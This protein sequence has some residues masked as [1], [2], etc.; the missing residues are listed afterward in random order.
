MTANNK[1]ASTSTNGAISNGHA[2]APQS[3]SPP[4]T[5]SRNDLR[6]DKPNGHDPAKAPNG[7]PIAICGMALRLPGGLSTPKELWN[8]LLAKG[9]A[10]TRVPESRYRASSF[11]SDRAKPTTIATQ[12]GY[13][14]DE[15]VDIGALDASFFSMS[16]TEVE[17]A[18]P[19]Q[20]LMLEI[21]REAFEDAGVT[22]WRGKSIGCYVGSFGEDWL[23]L[24]A[25][26]TQPW[27]MFRVTGQG[28]FM[29]SNR[30]SYEMDLQGPSVTVR[31]ACS[32]SLT[33][34]SEA[35]MAIS[36]GAC[37][38]A[39][40]GGVNLMLS[41]TM[42]TAMTEQGVLSKDGSC[43]TFSVDADGYAR[44]E[45]ATAIFIKP[46]AD[47]LRDGNPVRAV[48]R[49]ACHNSDGRTQGVSVPSSEAQEALIR[50]TYKLAGL[51][52]FR[53]TAMVECHGTGTATG[54]PIEAAAVARVFGDPKKT[55]YIGSV[56]PN[57]GHAE[58]AS[59]LV[60]IIKS[61]LALENRIIPPNI[62]FRAPNPNIPFDSAGMVVP[63][64]ATPWPQS[65]LER[66]SV[67]SF[68]IGGANAHAVLD[69]AQ[70]FLSHAPASTRQPARPTSRP[71]LM[72][73]SGN[74]SKSA[75]AAAA[76]YRSW[77]E[78]NPE[79]TADLAYTL[80]RHRVH[81]PW[82][83]FAT[84]QN[85]VLGMASPPTNST[86]KH[87]IVMVFTGQGAQWPGMGKE[88][89]ASQPSFKASI[90]Y[91]DEQLREVQQH[92]PAHGANEDGAT[93][94]Y[95]IEEELLKPGKKSRVGTAR[96]SQPL[97][98][99]I[100][101]ALVDTLRSFGVIPLAV[102]GHSSGEIAAAYAAGALTAREAIIAAHH[103]G[104]VA[105]L[106]KKKGAMAAIGMS[107][108]ETSKF[109]VHEPQVTI[110]C[111][112]SPESVTIS[113]DADAV[114][115]VVAD[116]QNAKPAVLTRLL[117]VDKAYHSYH[118]AEIGDQYSALIGSSVCGKASQ[119]NV[120]FFSSVTGN[121][122][123]A[124]CGRRL[125][126]VY[127]RENLQSPVRFRQ[128]IVSIVNH[129]IIGKEDA[130]FLEIGP[131]GALAGP[132][133]QILT[134][135][136]VS[137]PYISTLTR[138][139]NSMESIISAMG[140]LHCLHEPIDLEA[141][142]P[143]GKCLSNLPTYPWNH[144]TSYWAE[145]R[146]SRDWRLRQYPHHDLLGSKAAESTEIEPIWRNLLH[147]DNI[148][149]IRD[150]KVGD[151]IVFPFAGYIALA[152][153]AVKR[154]SGESH[155]GFKIRNIIVSVA[156]V[157]SED[158]PTEI[159][160]AFR[161]RRLT[162]T[163]SSHWWEFTVASHNGHTWNRHCTGEVMALG[164]SL[165]GKATKP[166]LTSLPRRIEPAAWYGT[167]C[168]GGLDLGPGFQRI[169]E[170]TTST[171]A[172]RKAAGSIVHGGILDEGSYHIHPTVIDGTLQLM[173]VAAVN[174]YARKVK[175]WLPT[176]I[177]EISVFRCYQD[178][179]SL[180]CAS[181]TSNLS[182]LGQGR[183]V[184]DDGSLVLEATGIRMTL[185]DG[186]Q[187]PEGSTNP[188]AAARLT[189][190]PNIEFINVRELFQPKRDRVAQTGI[191]YELADL[192]LLAWQS[193][194]NTERLANSDHIEKYAQWMSS[195][196]RRHG[197]R[198]EDENSTIT[199]AKVADLAGHLRDTPLAPAA[200]A[201]QHI[202]ENMPQIWNLG[203]QDN[204]LPSE[205]L[206]NLHRFLDESVD[207]SRF[208]RLLGHWKPNLRILEL[209]TA[210]QQ[211]S[212]NAFLGHLTLPE[213]AVLCS[214]YTYTSTGFISAKDQQQTGFAN[215]EYATLDISK[216]PLEQGFEEGQYDLIVATNHISATPCL[217]ES[218]ANVRRLLSP[219]GRLLLRELCPTSKWINMIYGLKQ[220]WWCGADDNR[221]EEPYISP[222][223]W[224]S[225]LSAAGF[226]PEGRYVLDAPQP[227]QLTATIV[228]RHGRWAPSEASP[229][230][231]TMLC[232]NQ[233]EG[234]PSY[235][236]QI[237]A[238]F[239]KA[240]YQV[241]TC[242]LADSPPRGQDVVSVLDESGPFFE[243]LDS[244]GFELLKNFLARLDKG[245]ML[246]VTRPCQ[247]NCRDP[248]Y[249]PVIGFAR[250]MRSEMLLDLATCEVGS[251]GDDDL[252]CRSVL[253]VSEA[254]AR[255]TKREEH[256]TLDADFEYLVDDEGAV[257]VG[258]FYPFALRDH[259]LA[260]EPASRAV[261]DVSTPGR[262]N[263]LRW[264]QQ[265]DE[266]MGVDELEVEVYSA[267]VNFRDILVALGIVELPV[268]QFG[269]EAAGVVT[270]TGT[271]VKDF[272]VGDRVI[273]LKKQAF[274]T[275]IITPQFACAK[276]P[277]GLSFDEGAT[278]LVPYLTA[279]YSLINVGGLTKGQ[280]V[281]IHSA[282]GGVGLA[283]IQVAQMLDADVY[284][285][286]GSDEKVHFL[287]ERFDIP[288]NKILHSRDDS[289]VHGLMGE[290]GG[291]GV[292]VVLNSLS[293]ELL[294]ATWGCVA[295][296]GRM[297]E[298]GKRDLIGGGKLDLKPFL[299]NRS[300]ACVDIDQ[301]WKR[302]DVLKRLINYT[303]EQYESGRLKP[304]QPIKMF[305]ASQMQDAFRYMQ[306]G[307]HIGRIGVSLRSTVQQAANNDHLPHQQD[308]EASQR[309]RHLTFNGKASYL[310]V[311]GLGGLGRA[312]AP[313]MADHNAKEIIFLSRNAGANPKDELLVDELRSIGCKA[314]LVTGDVTRLDDVQ[315]ALSSATYP[316]KGV[317]QMTMVLRDQSFETM[318]FEEWSQATAPKVQGTWNLH[319]ASIAAG[320]DLDF[321]V[322]FSS[323]SGI[324][325]QPGQANYSS[326]NTFLDS[327][328]Q[329][330]KSLGLPASVVD[331]GA[332]EEIGYISHSPGLM[333]KMKSTGFRG[334]SEQEL[335]DA[336]A[337]AMVSPK[338]AKHFGHITA[339]NDSSHFTGVDSFVLGLGF[340]SDPA[341]RAVWRKDRRMAVYH[342]LSTAAM[343]DPTVLRTADSTKFLAMEIGKKLFD[344]LLKPHEDLNTTWPLVDLGLDS[345]VAIELRAWWKQVFKF[346]ISVLEMMGMG[347]LEA[348][349]QHAVE[350][351]LG[352]ST[353]AKQ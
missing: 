184:A 57:L 169:R 215:M 342:N 87:R 245:G 150:H 115:R 197:F 183:C 213:G 222:Q 84:I 265:S 62:K 32:S 85:G 237:K 227:L 299:A 171:N 301:L 336:L 147:L 125:D 92:V 42:T 1:I 173:S 28:D 238:H 192:C 137:A 110:A 242:G 140:K 251:L 300:Y 73:F 297:V 201:L 221:S 195:E 17:R 339:E 120:A 261:V 205:M 83:S 256:G 134:S 103:R 190:A 16:R 144:D 60:S 218:L 307:Q 252:R 130:L 228:A 305:A 309:P 63:L 124:E 175:N 91:L 162:N 234:L 306:K 335:L 53:A 180:V 220:S 153:E 88:L 263:T 286:V 194:L 293:G 126:S 75:E 93:A 232:D 127:W 156:L 111:D 161:P 112:N 10:R 275:R 200:L 55:M 330:R 113:G 340:S 23:D 15:S 82:R 254:Y 98:T 2:I 208:L 119:G 154:L 86:R 64:E 351:L 241:S 233:S 348:L 352:L 178:M 109:V 96:L 199:S 290:T 320:L 191:L 204:I 258:R 319:N 116:V 210:G 282:C 33:C 269:L 40:V 324:I 59:G 56:K 141:I 338:R 44:G 219:E 158:R 19:Q 259:L 236:G 262:I 322:C 203:A 270:K 214:K 272:R 332:V 101:I 247:V 207:Q 165:L 46:L 128:A 331:I 160:T 268:R 350:G 138:N 11:Y 280:S 274:A 260:T 181:V 51:E 248:R 216:D 318:T 20:R 34:L 264:W 345:L 48:I 122:L 328:V 250:T 315:V 188:H 186:S 235:V 76:K 107:W 225:E 311:G 271:A 337:V 155:D 277:D 278:M 253:R 289:F 6:D 246:W 157:L 255:Q 4:D 295:E 47:A 118:M 185:A 22:Q 344:L 283:A 25:K 164:Q 287:T 50:R 224:I 121:H 24:N 244:D 12:Y 267:G 321:F 298:I 117:Q 36:T 149:W 80:A 176:S 78:N 61:V 296:F 79:M 135:E 343:S 168:R 58:G 5:Q 94:M 325:G 13:F 69:S 45:G 266:V 159:I 294:H 105:E 308:F 231:V 129:G 114:K 273:S 326:A 77:I 349:G 239:E 177:D 291:K 148:P 243:N 3:L 39:L 30:I 74:T 310:L 285:T 174:G 316:V 230:A 334:V 346:D 223:R 7:S 136:S 31:T 9:D 132:L 67:N 193:H 172:D 21:A 66:V 143:Q 102:V 284:A 353:E 131:H 72:L 292:D 212:S 312:I 14:L 37:D 41:P 123:D 152:G 313:W 341:N 276:I 170:I 211:S 27:G 163:L 327:M 317:L 166:Q 240:G 49:A 81:L 329:Y 95:S 99:A 8:F 226:D 281:L 196:A 54:D 146:I 206:H 35:C 182:L 179:T 198:C 43:K 257:N 189:W 347:S 97:C 217:Q 89:L 106:Q 202:C 52:D 133:R 104:A 151:D 314:H 70:R 304:V 333:N 18:D 145:S 100:Q 142:I 68:G 209:G 139:K 288:R 249:A 71:Q 229:K 303:L 167:L 38:A 187:L 279:I 302:P 65:K 29:L 323:L 26:E 90:E 108:E